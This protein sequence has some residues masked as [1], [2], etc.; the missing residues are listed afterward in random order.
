MDHRI[1]LFFRKIY[2]AKLRFRL[3]NHNFSLIASNCNG[4]C[5]L[6]DLGL[7]F[8]SP[9]VNLWV[10][11]K[12]FIKFCD[13]MDHYLSAQFTFVTEE[14]I[15]YPI[16]QLDDIRIYFQHYKTPDEAEVAWTRRAKRINRNNL[17][18]L[19]TDRDGWCY[20][21]FVAFEDLPYKNK[22]VFCHREYPEFPSAVYI[23]GFEHQEEVGLCM[24]YVSSNTFKKYYDAFDY[25]AWFNQGSKEKTTQEQDDGI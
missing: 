23:P 19:A 22:V 10:K 9:F 3:K 16:G 13:R 24:E 12:D 20:E 7:P 17:F 5:I 11:P 8:N 18:L 14:G 4:G 1:A 21:D 25:V 15:S 6:H 2:N